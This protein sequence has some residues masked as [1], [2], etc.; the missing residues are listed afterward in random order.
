[1]SPAASLLA[2]LIER[3]LAQH[4]A[5]IHTHNEYA[6]AHDAEGSYVA[7]E[8]VHGSYVVGI[9]YRTP[10]DVEWLRAHVESIP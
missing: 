5:T 6:E 4:V 10:S 1:M 2:W 7:W 8:A 9:K 3:D